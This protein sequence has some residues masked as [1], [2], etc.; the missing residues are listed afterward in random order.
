VLTV[1]CG[2]GAEAL[3]Q[4]EPLGDDSPCSDSRAGVSRDEPR[5]AVDFGRAAV[6]SV[7]LQPT[8]PLLPLL[9]SATAA[10]THQRSHQRGSRGGT[11]KPRRDKPVIE[12]GAPPAGTPVYFERQ[13]KHFCAMH[14]INN[15]LQRRL[16]VEADMRAQQHFWER[17][18]DSKGFDVTGQF[19]TPE[20]FWDTNVMQRALNTN[21]LRLRAEAYVSQEALITTSARL[22][23][24]IRTSSGLGH[25]VAICGPLK[26]FLDS[27]AK[28]PLR[29][30]EANLARYGVIFDNI[31]RMYSVQRL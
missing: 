2:A 26:L 9:P 15:V 30:T 5:P 21:A 6:I 16:L 22:L 13:R 8:A 3:V 28:K 17:H 12:L 29:L 11:N 23:I 19:G 20:G 27:A 10:D 7:A 24:M 31:M 4:G 1:L 18:W 14:A 25:T